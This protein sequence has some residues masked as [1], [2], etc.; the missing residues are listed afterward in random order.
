MP[1]PKYQF[2]DAEVASRRLA[3][4]ARVF[5]PSTAALL[6]DCDVARP[7]LAVDLGC[8]PG[9]T[10]RQLAAA[11]QPTRTFGLD[12]SE[13]FLQ[14]AR[15]QGGAE[16]FSHDVSQTPFPVPAPQLIFCRFLL[17]HL[18]NVGDVLSAWLDALQPGGREGVLEQRGDGALRLRRTH[19]LAPSMVSAAV[20]H[21]TALRAASP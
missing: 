12:R 1:D 4:L 19:G 2:G 15:A 8:G 21:D 18:S 10:T 17:S 13:A 6:A 9:W 20:V 14:E 16:Y 5:E 7:D 3:V 11:L